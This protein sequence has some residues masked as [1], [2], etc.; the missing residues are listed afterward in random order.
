MA[1]LFSV[2]IA[3]GGVFECSSPSKNVY[4]LSFEAPP[5]NRLVSDFCESFLLALNILEHNYPHGVLITTSAI[6]KFYS[7]GFI[8]QHN[9][10]T[11]GFMERFCL[12]LIK[13]LLMYVNVGFD[14]WKARQ[15]IV[16]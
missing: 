1:K 13:K 8:L 14:P 7:N 16:P 3:S 5:D 10:E 4:L 12:P 6:S 11:P 2:P 9:A 15:L